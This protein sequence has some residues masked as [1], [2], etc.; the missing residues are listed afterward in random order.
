MSNMQ[1]GCST[2]LGSSCYLFSTTYSHSNSIRLDCAGTSDSSTDCLVSTTI[3]PVP[4][5]SYDQPCTQTH[6]STVLGYDL[7]INK[8]RT[9]AVSDAQP[10]VQPRGR[11]ATSISSD[12][13]MTTSSWQLA[14]TACRVLSRALVVHSF[15]LHEL[16]CL[17]INPIPDCHHSDT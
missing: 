6:T 7:D 15:I 12:G 10:A 14:V 9:S 5:Q 1:H 17:L 13:G 11:L 4:E 8:K 2:S 16:S 3:N